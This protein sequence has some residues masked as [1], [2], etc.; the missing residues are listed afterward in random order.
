MASL[1]LA[2]RLSREASEAPAPAPQVQEDEPP[3]R[4]KKKKPSKRKP[5]PAAARPKARS[6]KPPATA[7]GGG[8]LERLPWELLGAVAK[9]LSVEAAA[10]WRGCGRSSAAGVGAL[11][12]E[13]RPE[14]CAG[15]LSAQISRIACTSAEDEEALW[16][17]PH[18]TLCQVC[19]NGGRVVACAYCNLVWHAGC[20]AEAA[21]AGDKWRC[22]ECVADQTAPVIGATSAFV[23]RRGDGLE[24]VVGGGYHFSSFTPNGSRYVASLSQSAAAWRRTSHEDAPPAGF[25]AS[26]ALASN[27]SVRCFARYGNGERTEGPAWD[28]VDA[29]PLV[30][31][32]GA[33]GLRRAGRW[34]TAGAASMAGGRRDSWRRRAPRVEAGAKVYASRG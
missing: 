8:T 16:A 7:V 11:W 19:G 29:P 21:A 12:G 32:A 27:G 31:A 4:P 33:G 22:P 20:L 2:L 28:A 18:N 26:D 17:H 23:R 15:E 10:R 13:D 30:A 3:A 25:S 5:K 34:M 9:F 14:L 24:L 6:R 1:R